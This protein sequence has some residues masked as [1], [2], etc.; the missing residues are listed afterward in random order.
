M[1]AQT[2]WVSFVEAN[3]TTWIGFVLAVATNRYV[4]PLFGF[5]ASWT[6]A[7]WITIIFTIIGIGRVYLVRRAFNWY[8][9]RIVWVNR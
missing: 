1:S 6:D 9:E 7:L 2:R 4:L 5:E 8:Q 3:V